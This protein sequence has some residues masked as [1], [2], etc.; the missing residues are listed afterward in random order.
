MGKCGQA[1]DNKKREVPWVQERTLVRDGV[2]EQHSVRDQH[3]RSAV[4]E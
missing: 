1:R 2:K 4:G 3:R